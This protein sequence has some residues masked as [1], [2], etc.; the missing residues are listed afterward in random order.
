MAACEYEILDPI[1]PPAS[2]TTKD[3]I[4]AA[5]GYEETELTLTTNNGT[6]TFTILT[7]IEE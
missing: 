2:Q 1:T 5:L 6:E 3:A 7:K 4:L